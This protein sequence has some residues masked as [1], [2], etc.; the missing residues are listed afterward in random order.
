LNYKKKLKD[1]Q[2]NLKLKIILR[3]KKLTKKLNLLRLAHERK[4]SKYRQQIQEVRRKLAENMINAEKNGNTDNC[5]IALKR[6][7]IDEYC[8]SA[9]MDD[10]NS[11]TDCRVPQNFC[12]LCCESEFGEMHHEERIICDNKCDDAYEEILI[13][14]ERKSHVHGETESLS[15]EVPLNRTFII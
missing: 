12:S 5:I 13:E 9:F 7:N 14:K 6:N 15:F 11:L 8:S 4:K 1:I 2:K 10:P 3:R